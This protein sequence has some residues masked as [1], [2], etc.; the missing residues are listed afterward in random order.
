MNM[1]FSISI[2]IGLVLILTTCDQ[3]YDLPTGKDSDT[4]GGLDP[5]ESSW[6]DFIPIQDITLG[7][8][9]SCPFGQDLSGKF[10]LPTRQLGNMT[11][12]CYALAYYSTYLLGLRYKDLRALSQEQLQQ[13]L[14][15][16]ETMRNPHYLCAQLNKRN[17]NEACNNVAVSIYDALENLMEEGF[18][19]IAD[20][21]P[22]LSGVADAS[23]CDTT[24]PSMGMNAGPT[25]KE[26]YQ[27]P[28]DIEYL[29]GNLCS[30]TPIIAGIRL[31]IGFEDMDE[32]TPLPWELPAEPKWSDVDHL[33]LIVGYA[34]EGTEYGG[35]T[36]DGAFKLLNSEG[37][38]WG[39]DGYLWV[40]AHS[41]ITMM[42]RVTDAN[43]K[44]SPIALVHEVD[45]PCDAGLAAPTVATNGQPSNGGVGGYFQLDFNGMVGA[46]SYTA[47]L[48]KSPYGDTDY[49][50]PLIDQMNT[51]VGESITEEGLYK[52]RVRANKAGC[53]VGDWLYSNEFAVGD[54]ATSPP[55]ITG[56]GLETVT[57]PASQTSYT[58]EINFSKPVSGVSSGITVNNGASITVDS[59][60]DSGPYSVTVSG[61]SPDKVFTV[62][63][64]SSITDGS[65]AL[66]AVTK[67][68]IVLKAG[69]G[70]ADTTKPTI[71]SDNFGSAS[72]LAAG[73][74]SFAVSVTFSEA[75]RNVD[76]VRITVDG[77]ASVGVVSGEGSGPYTFS[78]SG[79]QDGGSYTVTFGSG[80]T[81]S[82]GNGL[83]SV[84]RNISVQ[85]GISCPSSAPTGLVASDG[86]Y[87]DK[88]A[89]SWQSVVEATG[90]KIYRSTSSGS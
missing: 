29:A 15:R 28:A 56:G 79:L 75:V 50:L 64:G 66:S 4:I 13:Q 24:V 5:S 67:Q 51:R 37:Q 40:E 20:S 72:S 49:H 59:G 62:T 73:T 43:G 86:I 31:P 76:S 27:I 85:T 63:F 57:L 21:M 81:D 22:L 39:H 26:L 47:E 9:A 8:A 25:L 12:V 71:Q 33:L 42:K 48:G 36:A 77:G 18:P 30:Q 90:Y 65:Q 74:T 11:C 61:L 46:S 10:P 55:M 38:K 78:V 3:R 58:F 45:V 2:M 80:I 69:D 6:L 1:L 60:S 87:T 44:S 84:E 14:A 17:P 52:F 16:P 68:V 89:L 7:A 19:S 82:A 53:P 34:P 70:A 83:V 32:S 23:A 88:V 41:L 54:A 35:D